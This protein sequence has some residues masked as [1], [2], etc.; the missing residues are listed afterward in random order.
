MPGRKGQ[1]EDLLY[2]LLAWLAAADLFVLMMTITV[3]VAGRYLFNKPLPA[4]YE[5]VQVLMAVLV[6]T[7]LP[8]LCRTNE[9]IT[10][11][12]LHHLFTGRAHRLRLAFVHAFSA[13]VLGFI[14]WRLWAN[15]RKLAANGDA[16]AVLNLPLAPI[17]YVATVLTAISVLALLVL[18]LRTLS[19]P[20][21]PP[22]QR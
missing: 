9:H 5:L 4:G 17:G 16:T 15:T 11:D 18:A 19:A 1:A 21:L 13:A 20:A 2:R 14:D 8:L 10:V 12:L 22:A 3:D 7:S 6:F